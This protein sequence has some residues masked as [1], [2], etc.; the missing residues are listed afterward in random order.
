MSTTMKMSTTTMMMTKKQK[1]N[2]K[3][4]LKETYMNRSDMHIE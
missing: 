3:H 2:R 4:L 1:K